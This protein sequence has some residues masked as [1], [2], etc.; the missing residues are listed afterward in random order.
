MNLH[1]RQHAVQ[2]R[3]SPPRS[4]A[5]ITSVCRGG[6]QTEQTATGHRASSAVSHADD[7]D[8]LLRRDVT[9]YV[10]KRNSTGWV[11]CAPERD[12]NGP[13]S[14]LMAS[15]LYHRGGGQAKWQTHPGERP[16]NE[17][18]GLR[19]SAQELSTSTIRR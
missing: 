2:Q 9:M 10:A 8:T 15:R 7:A 17:A 4:P 12:Q 14:Q 13:D 3:L 18:S 11:T 6:E 16:G 19:Q 5:S 1:T